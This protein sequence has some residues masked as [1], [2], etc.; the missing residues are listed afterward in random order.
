[1]KR[2]WPAVVL[3]ALIAAGLAVFVWCRLEVTTDI[4]H[5]LPRGE[6][7]S[8][9]DLARRIATGELSRT[10]VLLLEARDQDE[11]VAASRVFEDSL[12]AEPDVAAALE[13]LD[14]GPPAGVEEALWTT[15]EGHRLSF[16]ASSAEAAAAR[17]TDEGVR[18]AVAELKRRLAS[19]MSSLVARVAPSDPF[20]VLP[21]LFE[22]V[23]GGTGTGLG[24]AEG[25][26]VTTDGT[27]A[28]LFLTTSA[29]A[30]D[31]KVQRPLLRGVQHAFDRTRASFGDHL[32]LRESGAHRHAIAAEESMQADMQRVSTVSLIGM[33][34]L[35]LLLFRSLRPA[36]LC[37]PVIGIGFLAGT[38]CCIA[39]F[40]QVHGLTLAFGSSLLGVSVDFSL[41]F[42]AHH[43]LM[44]APDGA[45]A[46]L[47]RIQGSLALCA[48]TTV[49][50]FVALL[51]ATFP[52][53][54]ELSLFAAVGLC[55]SL[56]ATWLVLPGLTG[57]VRTTR[58]C[59][60]V[61]GGLRRL[62][63]SRGRARWLLLAPGLLI[64]G[65]AAAGLPFARWDDSVK[66]LNRIDPELK[67]E[68]DAVQARV[69]RFEQRRVVVAAGADEQE[70]LARNERVLATLRA[71]KAAGEIGDFGSAAPLVPS[72]ATQVAVADA[73]RT[74]A[75]LWPR[76]QRAL[77]DQGFVVD[78]FAP[79]ADHLAQPAP[80]PTTPAS[81][82]GTPLQPLIRPFRADGPEGHVWLSFVHELRDEP[83]LRAR[84]AGIDGARVLDIEGALTGALSRYRGSMQDLLTL[85]V[86]AVVVLVWLRHRRL[87][88]TL[89]ACL[90]PL[91]AA[92][93][94]VGALALAGVPMNLMTLM[95]LLMIVSMGD[96]YGIFLV[97]DADE[98]SRDATHLSVLSSSL[99]TML[100]FGLLALSVQP[101]L[102][103]IGI[104]SSIGILF[105]VVLA[106][107]TGALFAYPRST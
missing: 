32:R 95:A 57:T 104:V 61:T 65:V 29:K 30:T 93:G 76:L 4:T 1:M 106:L 33:V 79:F 50:G 16:F 56:G 39:V 20:L 90:P 75:T 40:G 88:P 54:R 71:A 68:D 47:R 35:Y 86:L 31:S 22:A 69:V 6:R 62:E 83:A 41:H 70:A 94:T 7:D 78:A 14:G 11:A 10:L 43:A 81:L 85:G 96:D 5:F 59:R 51:V 19:P 24:V 98:A 66:G 97:D 15:Y 107:S 12:R 64:V 101:A 84:L 17:I 103:S 34:L 44:P 52:G 46:T 45:R 38:A 60:A 58:L 100:G 80:E 105:C 26:F 63:H 3:G 55:A 42:Y 87:R 13:S 18:T 74:D 21:A 2:E 27:A 67:A 37:V 53:L 8:E 28:V 102:F 36:L 89:V 99:T 73:V 92:A 72:R 48:A 49:T 25:R 23:G 77:A 82:A 91:L 9:V